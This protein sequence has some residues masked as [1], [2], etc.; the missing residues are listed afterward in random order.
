MTQR[1]DPPDMHFKLKKVL[2]FIRL[3]S[4]FIILRIFEKVLYHC[5]DLSKDMDFIFVFREP[6]Y[7]I[8]YLC[9]FFSVYSQNDSSI[10]VCHSGEAVSKEF[11]C[12]FNVNCF[13]GSDE[14][15]CSEYC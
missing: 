14:L 11:V 13:D 6:G 12:D 7:N 10:F 2:A 5:N 15:N 4:N 3:L 9:I 8:C 1:V